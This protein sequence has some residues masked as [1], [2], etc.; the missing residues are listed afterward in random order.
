MAAVLDSMA[1]GCP[2]SSYVFGLGRRTHIA[3]AYDMLDKIGQV[4]PSTARSL[5]G[6]SY[7]VLY[8]RDVGMFDK[9]ESALPFTRHCLLCP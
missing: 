9:Q 5:Q 1:L 2:I 7:L 6:Q 3:S 8:L 4:A